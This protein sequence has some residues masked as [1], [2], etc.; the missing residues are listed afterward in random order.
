MRPPR[1][2][3][4]ILGGLDP[5]GEAGVVADIKAAA[6]CGVAT[7]CIITANTLQNRHRYLSHETVSAA[8][9]EAQLRVLWEERPP[10]A[11]KLGMMPSLEQALVLATFLKTVS[12]QGPFIW[13]PVLVSSSGGALFPMIDFA[14]IWQSLSPHLTGLTPNLPEAHRILGEREGTPEA[15]VLDLYRQLQVTPP[16]FILLKGGHGE[17]DT[18]VD[19]LYDGTTLQPFSHP[20]INRPQVSRGTGCRLVTTLAA[21]LIQSM[22]L[23]DAVQTAR[24][25]VLAYLR[26]E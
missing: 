9:I 16:V 3:L 11:I 26:E 17:A 4:L 5:G 12:W 20:R 13:D 14:A 22:T 21:S 1:P 6:A 24:H 8:M 23:A 10:A 19:W 2:R 18:V 7:S 25:F 15:L